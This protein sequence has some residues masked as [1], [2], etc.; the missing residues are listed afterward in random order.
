MPRRFIIG[1]SLIL[2]AI[3]AGGVYLWKKPMEPAITPEQARAALLKLGRLRVITGGEGDPIAVDLRSG[4]ITWTDASRLT[5][6]RFFSCN[7]REKTW[8]M[9]FSNGRTGRAH[10][11]TGANGRFEWQ[12]DGTWLAIETDRFIT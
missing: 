1:A 10:F 6:G 3:A 12:S 5:I 8:R 11:S 4:A 7:L 2:L 9:A